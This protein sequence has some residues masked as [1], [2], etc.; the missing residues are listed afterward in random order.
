MKHPSISGDS[1]KRTGAPAPSRD[2]CETGRPG[3]VRQLLCALI[4][5]T[6]GSLSQS[7]QAEGSWQLGLFEG[8]SH[9]QPLEE[10][11]AGAGYN[12]FHVDIL[13]PGEVINI[14]ACG[15]S[16]QHDI[17]VEIY[18]ASGTLVYSPTSRTAT[19]QNLS[20]NSDF[21]T[22]FDPAVTN[23]FQFDQTSTG[24]YEVHLRNLSGTLLNRVDVSVTNTTSDII[25]PR[26]D[27]GRVWSRFWAFNAGAYDEDSSTD[28]DLHVVADGGFSGTHYVW[29]LDLNNFA[30]FA[31]SL[32]A[33]DLGVNS[34]NLAG[35]VVAGISVPK[36]GNSMTELHPV[37]LSYPAKTY[38]RPVNTVL[39]TNYHFSDSDGVDSTIS[40]GSSAGTQDYGTFHF[41]TNIT[42]TAV[43]EIIIDIDDGSGGGPDG[44][45]GKGDIFLRGN[46]GFGLNQVDWDGT[47][48]N[49]VLTPV[50]SY[51][52]RLTVRTGEFHFVADDVETSGGPGNVGVRIREAI[53][54][55]SSVPTINY[56]D[57]FTVMNGT[58]ADAFN[59]GGTFDGD[60]NWG[61]FGSGGFGNAALI[62]T[63]VYGQSASPEAISASIVN[64]DE[65]RPSIIKSFSPQSVTVGTTATMSL[66]IINNS[67]TA[68]NGI[69]FT[70]QLPTGMVLAEVPTPIDVSGVGCTGF[71]TGP[72]T[73]IGGNQYDI[74][75]GTLPGSGSCTIEIDV[76]ASLPGD[77]ENTT[78]GVGSL[79]S[80][81]GPASNTAILT[82]VPA[83][84]GPPFVCDGTFY[85]DAGSTTQTRLYRVNRNSDTY[86]LEEFSGA[87]YSATS[88]YSYNALGYNPVDNYLYAVVTD[89]TLGNPPAST[90]LRIDSNGGITN[91]A[92]AEPGPSLAYMPVIN[93]RFRGGAFDEDG[94]FYVVTD[95]GGTS[96]LDERSQIMSI[97][98]S[99]FPALVMSRSTHGL[100][101]QDIA[102]DADG[103]IHAVQT[104]GPLVTIDPD[105]GAV[106]TIGGGVAGE[107]GSLFFDSR[108][109]LYLRTDDG[110]FLQLDTATGG[111]TPVANGTA[112]ALHDGASCNH[113]VDFEKS[114]SSTVVEAGGTSSY[115]FSI[116]NQTDAALSFD[117]SDTLSDGRSFVAA[118]LQNP[119]GGSA[120]SYADTN[121]LSLS[122][123]VLPANSIEQVQ[124]DVRFPDDQAP[125]VLYNQALLSNLPVDLG[126]SLA[127]DQ[128]GTAPV[129]D[130]T[131]I[132]V[133]GRPLIGSAKNAI[134]S[135]TSVTFDLIVENP[136][137][138]E[139]SDVSLSDD[140][141]TVFGA[142]NY[143]ITTAPYFI[144][145]PG[146]LTLDSNFTGSGSNTAILDVNAANTLAVGASARI[147]LEVTVT[148]AS[149]M[150]NGPGVY[151][152]QV[153]AA[154]D[155]SLGTR[156]SDLSDDGTTPDS[157]GDGD[158]T[159]DIG[160]GGDSD[161]NDPSVFTLSFSS[162]LSGTVFEDNGSGGA[163]PHD[164]VHHA[165]EPGYAG[166]Q[167]KALDPLD[168][169]ALISSTR[170][171]ADGSYMLEVPPDTPVTLSIGTPS[172]Y[173]NISENTGNSGASN[174]DITDGELS[175]T[176]VSGTNYDNLD[177]GLIRQ[178]I[179]EPDQT[180]SIS[181]G[182]SVGLSHVYRVY[183]DASVSLAFTEI[184]NE[185]TDENWSRVLY[186]DSDCNAELNSADTVLDPAIAISVDGQS[187]LCLIVKISSTSP[188]PSGAQAS[189]TL[190]ATT[191]FSDPTLTGHAGSSI[192]SVRDRVGVSGSASG[193]LVLRK[194]VVNVTQGSSESASGGEALPGDVLR[195]V[196]RFSNTGLGPI[197]DLQIHDGMPAFSLLNTSV[198][199]PVSL[200]DTLTACSLIAPTSGDNQSGYIGAIQWSFD[201][202][203]APGASGEVQYD[204]VVE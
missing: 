177:F 193:K 163:T 152:N 107:A 94:L 149:D 164:G 146:T 132:N 109:D 156:V 16:N 127:S 91:L 173:L 75:N 93:T 195:Y 33:N 21:D 171:A 186:H 71:T 119:L 37:Y 161:E 6:L 153:S 32:K 79:Q 63:Y 47:D 121:T 76:Q 190:Q 129:T 22:T 54:T 198:S 159:E 15:E 44:L 166:I 84:S 114:T 13:A 23:P 175:F 39:V 106:S 128:P 199:C 99:T 197:S 87:G 148:E 18:N 154:G 130:L 141:D 92:I 95:A 122:G 182:S 178:A 202:T 86:Y 125:G 165:N 36:T 5:L 51:S 10:T 133:I 30:G 8:L 169:N 62:D 144:D 145:D 96:P 83:A 112:A 97:D 81:V 29:Q 89:T 151:S 118:S 100:D 111:T 201:G 143:Q 9:A 64:T 2:K 183:S 174:P 203:L 124:I 41:T 98:V 49:G 191:T 19:Q 105:S 88:G 179:L 110:S 58:E 117:L 184:H 196:I 170:T 27:A 168:S 12:I 150:G 158:P 185:P 160:S 204:T 70:D 140:L 46:A 25:D 181:A 90:L 60:H 167:V 147:R 82:V 123:L 69:N 139:L 126:S 4:M 200:P 14:F 73:L 135:G 61:T 66:Q 103:T 108:N 24:T 192:Q 157:D 189:H 187:P 116:A 43:Y 120:N 35:D 20:C 155:S 136:G 59:V 57:D 113:G 26:D 17:D 134:V 45:Y 188:T 102:V 162:S 3:V 67:I 180:A 142:G 40:P 55:F 194:V 7:L 42:S 11:N 78:S 56:W 50:G 137:A 28:A 52:S 176:P 85:V 172:G 68:L 72:T 115:V 131:P 31:Y 104:S 80:G 1:R 65:P 38:S 53:S 77:Y 48:N 138:S 74:I 34:P 101:I